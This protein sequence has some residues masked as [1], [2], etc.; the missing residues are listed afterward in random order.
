M[1][2]LADGQFEL[3]GYLFGDGEVVLRNLDL[4]ERVVANHDVSIG[5]MGTRYMGRDR[6][7]APELTLDLSVSAAPGR[8]AREVL[9]R[10][11]KTWEGPAQHPGQLSALR[12]NLNGDLG[13]VLGR[14]RR[15]SALDFRHLLNTGVGD[16]MATFQL[17]DMAFYSDTEYVARI[18]VIPPLTTGLKSPLMAPLT[19]EG[20]GSPR[21]GFVVN[22][23]DADSPV[24][25]TFHGPVTNPYVR[26]PGWLVQLNTHLAHDR[27]V[28][29]D[30]RYMTV[31]DDQGGNRAG[32]LSR[33]SRL[34]L[35]KLPPGRS[36]LEFSGSGTEAWMEARWRDAWLSI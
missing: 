18:D 10:L 21:A 19:T 3:D 33:S 24:A 25:V 17:A 20:A 29:L 34:D 27:S 7:S 9:R 13:Y 1:S 8:P 23:G 12:Y 32:A 28:T 31:T 35:M 14:P 6:E 26:G 36:E 16:V 4:G 30:A 15:F 5:T 11:R 22:H 2:D